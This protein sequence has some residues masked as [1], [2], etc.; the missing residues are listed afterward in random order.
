[1]WNT[2]LFSVR[3]LAL[4]CSNTLLS[5]SACVQPCIKILSLMLYAFG[6]PCSVVCMAVWKTSDAEL[7]PNISRLYLHSFW[8]ALKIVM[9]LDSGASSS[10]WYPLFQSKFVKYDDPFSSKMMSSI[11]GVTCSTGR[12]AWF[13]SRISTHMLSSFSFFGLGWATN[14]LTHGVGPSDTSSMMS[15]CF[16]FSNFSWTFSLIYYGI[17]L[18]QFCTGWITSIMCSLTWARF[19][20]PVPS[21]RYL[22]SL[23]SF[24]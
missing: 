2:G 8:F 7:K 15:N 22:Y 16:S 13:A 12:T 4:I 24:E 19:N 17:L 14:G 1:M 5:C 10:W 23:H 3:L 18:W 11:G 9:Y 20:L 21:K 6:M